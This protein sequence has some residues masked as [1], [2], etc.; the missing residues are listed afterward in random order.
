MPHSLCRYNTNSVSKVMVPDVTS[1][2]EIVLCVFFPHL[3]WPWVLQISY[4]GPLLP[5]HKADNRL[6]SSAGAVMTPACGA[7][8]VSHFVLCKAVGWPSAGGESMRV[9]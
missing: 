3:E 4:P 7:R 9:P 5:E 1:D 8:L 6:P 2:W